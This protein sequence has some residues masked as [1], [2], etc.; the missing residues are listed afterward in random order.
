[1][2]TQNFIAKN[3]YHH[4]SLV[5]TILGLATWILFLHC[6]LSRPDPWIGCTYSN[7]SLL[8]PSMFFAAYPFLHCHT[9]MDL[10]YT[11]YFESQGGT[12]S[13]KFWLCCGSHDETINFSKFW[14]ELNVIHLFSWSYLMANE[15]LR[16]K[17]VQHSRVGKNVQ[18]LCNRLAGVWLEW[19]SNHRVWHYDMEG[20][21]CWLLEGSS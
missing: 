18:G 8:L 1:M 12:S 7:I 17:Q 4:Q 2:V 13:S 15:V 20:P 16:C 19:Q 21:S 10:K 3:N 6:S 9:W 5:P 11:V 14:F